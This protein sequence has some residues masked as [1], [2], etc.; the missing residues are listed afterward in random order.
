MNERIREPAVAGVFYPASPR[1][2]GEIVDGLLA[3]AARSPARWP[4]AIVAPHAGYVYSGPTAAAAF[5]LV[6]G[7]PIERVVLVGPSHRV[8]LVGLA[9]PGVTALKTPLGVIPVDTEALARL[10]SVREDPWAHSREHSLEVELPFVQ[11]VAARARVVPLVVGR[12]S[13]Q[14]VGEVLD[15]LWGG[16]ET[17]IVVSSDLS[18]YLP[19]AI[20]QGVDERTA[21]SIVA[22]DLGLTEDQACG[23]TALNG[24]AW[25]ARRRGLSAELVE[26]TSS[27]DT[28]GPRD[29]VVGYGAFA[30]FEGAAA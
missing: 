25:V 30:F 2:L 6:V 19:Y 7:A 26:L 23:A 9:S 11:R 24:L 22:L 28:A 21:A 20:G 14:E 3:Q 4:K 15:A 29:K 5:S 10:V 17:L 13:A 18:H 12:S 27:G 1:V 16:P 8:P